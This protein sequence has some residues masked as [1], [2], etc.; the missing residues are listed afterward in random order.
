M[1]ISVVQPWV[2]V[3]DRDMTPVASSCWDVCVEVPM[4]SEQWGMLTCPLY[5]VVVISE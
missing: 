3:A 1:F 4:D 2:E 5:L